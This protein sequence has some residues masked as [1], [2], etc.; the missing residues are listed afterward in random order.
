M[1]FDVTIDGMRKNLDNLVAYLKHLK[2]FDPTQTVEHY[3]SHI[4]SK[5]TPDIR[6]S[7]YS[8]LDVKDLEQNMENVMTAIDRVLKYEE[9]IRSLLRTINPAQQQST[10]DRPNVAL[11]TPNPA[12][13]RKRKECVF[14]GQLPSTKNCRQVPN[15]QVSTITSL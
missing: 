7:A 1:P 2:Q 9:K 5:F 10:E 4:L 13:K 11:L 6:R 3:L 15:S 12:K 14:C 8:Y